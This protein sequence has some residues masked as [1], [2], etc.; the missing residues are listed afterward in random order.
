MVEKAENPLSTPLNNP[1]YLL[2][3]HIGSYRGALW[4]I[5]TISCLAVEYGKASWYHRTN[6]E[7][8]EITRNVIDRIEPR[9]TSR[10][11]KSD[12]YYK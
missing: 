9:T 12:L 4:N 11:V 6:E 10:G 3:W 8:A 5:S 1:F 2:G 7:R